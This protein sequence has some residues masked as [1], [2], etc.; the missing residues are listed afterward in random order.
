M[1]ASAPSIHYLHAYASQVLHNPVRDAPRRR[2]SFMDYFNPNSIVIVTKPKRFVVTLE[3]VGLLEGFYVAT[4]CNCTVN[5]GW[6]RSVN[7]WPEN[8]QRW[9]IEILGL[10]FATGIKIA[11]AIIRAD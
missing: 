5:V 9:E 7:D 4:A 1:R 2:N 6:M 8:G 10:D 11:R 3:N